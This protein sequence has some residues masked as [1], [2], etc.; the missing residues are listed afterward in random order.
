MGI[1]T[2]VSVSNNQGDSAV[3]EQLPLPTT[4]LEAADVAEKQYE[5]VQNQR[6]TT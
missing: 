1:E 4:M 6:A 5:S 2:E 3:Q